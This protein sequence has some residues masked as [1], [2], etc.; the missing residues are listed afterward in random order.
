M[1]YISCSTLVS[2]T[3]YKSENSIATCTDK[4][5]VYEQLTEAQLSQQSISVITHEQ[6]TALVSFLV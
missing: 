2:A 6:H 1:K 5:I 4:F 3:L